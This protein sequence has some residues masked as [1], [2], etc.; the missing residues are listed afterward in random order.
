MT[1]VMSS[2]ELCNGEIN[3]VH[4]A[5]F[6]LPSYI[7]SVSEEGPE[8]NKIHILKTVSLTGKGVEQ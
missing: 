8:S 6:W 5:C 1:E 7:F 3:Q 2:L 4:D